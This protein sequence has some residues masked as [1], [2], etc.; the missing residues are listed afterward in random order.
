[1]RGTGRLFPDCMLIVTL[2]HV[3]RANIVIREFSVG[4]VATGTTSASCDAASSSDGNV[5]RTT[6]ILDASGINYV[7]VSVTA[8][9]NNTATQPV[10]V[11]VAPSSTTSSSSTS[12]AAAQTAAGPWA[13]GGAIGAGLVALAAL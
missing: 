13:M 7:A 10:T 3:D 9:N 1:M 12:S 11:T 4:C 6:S 8:T 2:H 5:Q